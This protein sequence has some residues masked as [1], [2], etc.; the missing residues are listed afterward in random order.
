MAVKDTTPRVVRAKRLGWD[1]ELTPEQELDLEPLDPS[2]STDLEGE[3]EVVT[4]SSPEVGELTVYLVGGQEADPD[5]IVD[6]IT[7]N[8]FCPT[9]KGGGIDNTCPPKG[10]GKKKGGGAVPPIATDLYRM[11]NK[12]ERAEARKLEKEGT[13]LNK[14]VAQG[15]ATDYEITRAGQIRDRM[16]QI[17]EQVRGRGEKF[18]TKAKAPRKAKD[19]KDAVKQEETQGKAG[20]PGESIYTKDVAERLRKQMN[21]LHER[22]EARKILAEASV[23]VGEVSPKHGMTNPEKMKRLTLDDG[24]DI[25]YAHGLEDKA[26][27]TLRDLA[28]AKA[29]GRIPKTLWEA[30]NGIYHT[31]QRNNK[32][33]YWEKEYGIPGFTSAATGGDG[34]IVVYNGDSMGPST[35]NHEAGHNLATD[36]YGSPHPNSYPK[37]GKKYQAARDYRDAQGQE[38]PVS[39]YGA[40]SAAEDFAEFARAYA[41]KPDRNKLREKFPKKYAA[42]SQLIE[43]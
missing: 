6:A 38:K 15:T 4:A 24:L 25:Y 36:L 40:K 29:D 10:A 17:R 7:G 8:A 11:M 43:D 27:D 35:F 9:G 34:R 14:K 1:E 5:T 2:L 32:D 19:T 16:A 21:Y 41:S 3:L 33:P 30:N 23:D 28:L 31:T 13:G 42:F 20:K 12:D 22:L 39:G 18:E 26:A 37:P